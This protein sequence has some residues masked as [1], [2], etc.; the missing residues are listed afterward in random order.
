M[1]GFVAEEKGVDPEE[2][3]PLTWNLYDVPDAR[4]FTINTVELSWVDI[5]LPAVVLSISYSDNSD[6]IWDII[7]Y[8]NITSVPFTDASQ[9]KVTKALLMS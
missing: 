6:T 2:T 4:W 9:D 5:I 1:A 3:I 8:F 7:S